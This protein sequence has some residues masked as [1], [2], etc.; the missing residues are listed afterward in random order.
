MARELVEKDE[1]VLR[2]GTWGAP[3]NVLAIRDYMNQRKVPQLFVSDTNSAM[4]DPAHFPWTMGFQPSKRTEASQR[5]TCRAGEVHP[6]KI[7]IPT[8]RL[9]PID[10]RQ[11]GDGDQEWVGGKASAMGV[12][13]AGDRS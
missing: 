10:L 4:D 3:W 6:M 13:A 5:S 9:P 2:A 11:C 1:V 7:A 8:R 12:K